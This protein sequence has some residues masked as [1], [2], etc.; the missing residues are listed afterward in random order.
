M[1]PAFGMDS[2]RASVYLAPNDAVEVQTGTRNTGS[3]RLSLSPDALRRGVGQATKI[4]PKEEEDGRAE[5]P[6]TVSDGGMSH[7]SSKEK[8]LKEKIYIT[9]EEP[10][11]FKPCA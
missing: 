10:S 5:S 7:Q 8:S 11:R 3:R 6:V 2:P 1:N 4:H 9:L